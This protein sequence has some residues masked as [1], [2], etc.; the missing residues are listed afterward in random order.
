MTLGARVMK[1]E[2]ASRERGARP[3]RWHTRIWIYPDQ[4][5]PIDGVQPPKPT[6]EAPGTCP[7]GG[8]LIDL[9]DCDEEETRPCG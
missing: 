4:F 6:C 3:C 8:L 7:G 2:A 1:L 5:T 9:S